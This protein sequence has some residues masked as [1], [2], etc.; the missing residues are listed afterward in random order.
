MQKIK[1]VED[2]ER[3]VSTAAPGETCIYHT[4]VLANDREHKDNSGIT[5]GDRRLNL[6]AKFALRWEKEGVLYL[7]QRR[8]G[9]DK[10]DYIAVRASRPAMAAAA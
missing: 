2:L 10:Y 8:I 4:G 7:L 5:R 9:V 3:F 1:T 6:L